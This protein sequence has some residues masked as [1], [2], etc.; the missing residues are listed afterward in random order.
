MDD[1]RAWSGAAY[2]RVIDER[3]DTVDE[4]RELERLRPRA[5]VL[6]PDLGDDERVPRDA[7]LP[8]LGLALD[9][10][11]AGVVLLLGLVG[12]YVFVWV[13]AL[14][15]VIWAIPTLATRLMR[16][17]LRSHGLA[18]LEDLRLDQATWVA[19]AAFVLAVMVGTQGPVAGLLLGT[20][21][22][23]G[24]LNG[25]ILRTLV[26]LGSFCTVTWAV[27]FGVATR[28]ALRR[29]LADVLAWQQVLDGEVPSASPPG[30]QDGTTRG[31][32]RDSA[33][34]H[35][36]SVVPAWLTYTSTGPEPTL[37]DGSRGRST[38]ASVALGVAGVMA[39]AAVAYGVLVSGFIIL[40]F[41]L[42][43]G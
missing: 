14:P 29:R 22:R 1:E 12:S 32:D 20:G 39:L 38:T 27:T 9:V 28:R 25:L 3:G 7:R 15:L 41:W 24:D 37:G 40:V 8:T 42:A 2:R 10:G 33:V 43:G 13:T 26:V 19:A 18:R 23:P 36:G 21:G 35:A 31:T 30:L 17:R 16:R 11:V 34:W 6:L 4:R 5:V